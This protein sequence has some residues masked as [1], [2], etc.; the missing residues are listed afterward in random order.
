MIVKGQNLR[1]FVNQKVILCA[2]ACT[3]HYTADLEETSTKDDTGDWKT[4]E[5]VGKSWDGSADAL[6]A[7]DNTTTAQKLDDL[8]SLIGV[9]VG[10]QFLATEGA[11]NRVVDTGGFARYGEAIINDISI[12]AGNRQNV[13][14]SIQFTGVGA[15][16]DGPSAPTT[17]TE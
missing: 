4:S 11:N 8:T 14:Y 12:N 16:G 9:K 7:V 17:P 2:T 1:L 5:C 6:M 10:V 15:L 3:I 13:T